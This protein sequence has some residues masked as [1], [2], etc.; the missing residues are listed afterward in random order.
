MI[1]Q[2]AHPADRIDLRDIAIDPPDSIRRLVL[3]LGVPESDVDELAER[4]AFSKS[5]NSKGHHRRGDPEFWREELPTDV[6]RSFQERWGR[7]LE[8]LGYPACD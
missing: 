8:L 6:L 1:E 7:P 4:F 3:P 5:R 2:T